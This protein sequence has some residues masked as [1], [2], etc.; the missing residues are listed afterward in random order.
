MK[1]RLTIL[2]VTIVI[3]LSLSACSFDSGDNKIY[4]SNISLCG[5]KYRTYHVDFVQ[6]Y[7]KVNDVSYFIYEK[8]P[9]QANGKSIEFLEKYTELQIPDLEIDLP[10]NTDFTLFIYVLFHDATMG[11]NSFCVESTYNTD[12]ITTNTFRARKIETENSD[13]FNLEFTLKR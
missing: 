4:L 12:D 13:T 9:A 11:S 10:V 8:H 2:C 5:I 7:Y 3:L 6:I 1:K